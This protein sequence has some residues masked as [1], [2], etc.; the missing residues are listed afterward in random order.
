MAISFLLISFFLL[1][2]CCSLTGKE[3]M[4]FTNLFKVYNCANE[5]NQ[6]VKQ[7]ASMSE[8]K[9]KVM[10][11]NGYTYEIENYIKSS[12][13]LDEKRKQ[14]YLTFFS[15][16]RIMFLSTVNLMEIEDAIENGSAVQ[17]KKYL[18]LLL[19]T[20]K[21]VTSALNEM[22]DVQAKYPD[23][24]NEMNCTSIID[25]LELLNQGTYNLEN[26]IR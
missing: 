26:N 11:C 3:A 4:F 21:N 10:E 16:M 6:L 2:G 18:S 15:S 1:N 7:N 17:D 22:K 9:Q 24:C 8:I 13:Y 12:D 14:V 25:A 19:E 20:R 23:L 5:F